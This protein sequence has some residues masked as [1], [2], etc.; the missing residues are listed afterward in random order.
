MINTRKT[1]FKTIAVKSFF[2]V[3]G[4]MWL[5]KS[6]TTANPYGR[7]TQWCFFKQSEKVL[8]ID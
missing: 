1:E 8:K 6:K 3:D 4:I 7:P 2:E 5:K